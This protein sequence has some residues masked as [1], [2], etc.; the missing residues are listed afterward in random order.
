[1]H[2]HIRAHTV[3]VCLTAISC[4]FKIVIKFYVQT[5]TLSYTHKHKHFKGTFH[6][7]IPA[8]FCQTIKTLSLFLFFN[9]Y[10]LCARTLFVRLSHDCVCTQPILQ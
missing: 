7:F 4:D 3:T 10:I 6:Q 9:R 2:T 8:L 1:M 5:L